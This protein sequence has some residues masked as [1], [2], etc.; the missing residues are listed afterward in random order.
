VHVYGTT[1]RGGRRSRSGRGDAHAIDGRGEAAC[2]LKGL[3]VLHDPPQPWQSDSSLRHCPVCIAALATDVDLGPRPRTT[4][5][6]LA[7]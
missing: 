4:P 5:T 7:R 1:E 6:N 2:G 3:A